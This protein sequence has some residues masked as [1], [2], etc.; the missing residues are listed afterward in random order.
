MLY[1][2]KTAL[3][4]RVIADTN[5]EIRGLEARYDLELSV[6]DR[7]LPW[8]FVPNGT[9]PA[10]SQREAVHDLDYAMLRWVS[11]RAERDEQGAQDG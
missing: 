2:I 9:M 4:W 7:G 8:V 11:R 5:E 1:R 3:G 6:T 10:L